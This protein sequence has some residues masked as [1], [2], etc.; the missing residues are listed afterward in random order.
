ML[1]VETFEMRKPLFNAFPG[2]AKI[3]HK[4]ILKNYELLFVEMYITLPIH[5]VKMC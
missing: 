2:R 3:K 5:F 1:A 4:E